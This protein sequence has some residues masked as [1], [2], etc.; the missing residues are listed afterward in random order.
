M[1]D[2][3]S[4]QI[5]GALIALGGVALGVISSW[6]IAI[7]NR[8]YDDRRHMRQLAIETALEYWKQD[9]ATANKIGE[10][11]RR[12]V[13]IQPLD[14]YVVHMLQLADLISSKRL[15]AANAEQELKRVISVSQAA[16]KASERKPNDA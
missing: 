4:P 5:V 8:H 1:P 11:T 2:I 6:V 12:N 16:A 13:T 15:T 3:T 7:I 14:T 9:I 10:L